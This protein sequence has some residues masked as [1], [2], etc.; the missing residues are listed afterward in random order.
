[1]EIKKGNYRAEFGLDNP[2]DEDTFTVIE[3]N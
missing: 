1:M 2:F 3:L